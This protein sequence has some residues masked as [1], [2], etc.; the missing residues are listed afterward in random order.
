MG[1]DEY[2]GDEE[3]VVTSTPFHPRQRVHEW[4]DDN[5]SPIHGSNRGTRTSPTKT[6]TRTGRQSKPPVRFDPSQYWR[7]EEDEAKMRKGKRES[8]KSF[9]AEAERASR[10]NTGKT[11]SAHRQSNVDEEARPGPSRVSSKGKTSTRGTTK[12]KSSMKK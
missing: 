10:T 11:R 3:D 9:Q 1:S 7:D 6:F 5:E 12:A 8:N 2:E 4:L